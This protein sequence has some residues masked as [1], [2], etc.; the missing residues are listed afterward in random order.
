MRVF[1]AIVVGVGGMGS[2]AVY[3]LARRGWNVLGL[4]QFDIPHSMGSSHGLT[5]IIRLAYFEHP[6][7]VPL[8]R[9]AYELWRQLEG[10]V[11]EDLLYTTGSVDVGREGSQVFEGSLA[12]CREFGLEHEILDRTQLSLRFPA[13]RLPRDFH[14]VLQPDGG[15]LLSERCIVNHVFRALAMGAEVRARET[16]LEWMPVGGDGVRVITDAGRYEA[17]R[18]VITA[19][20]WVSKLIPQL[21]DAAV[22]ER[23]VLGWFQPIEPA[24]F[25][26]G[27]FPVFNFTVDEGHFYG[28]PV[29]LVPG[30]KV[31]RYHHLGEVVD[32][33][34][35]SRE[36]H[37]R[38]E[39][40]LREFVAQYF[41]QGAGP[42]MA[43]TTCM[44]TNSPDEHFIIDTLHE[45]PQVSVAAGFSGHGY[46]FASVVGEIMS[47]LAVDGTTTHDI[48]RFS[49]SRFAANRVEI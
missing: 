45:F 41:P 15:F 17:R 28:F 14:A 32:A 22:P 27:R 49:L 21:R 29:F 13:Y 16:V 7:Y 11:R 26:L 19:G 30:L 40:V 31:G 44:F 18:L 34:N 9:R 2:A 46:K 48:H 4:E 24:L 5:R 12:S 36:I 1:D 43:L 10:E 37:S 33:D 25:Q 39:P 47:D 35:V 3:H 23:Q 20:A 6:T 8:L 38:D 42:T